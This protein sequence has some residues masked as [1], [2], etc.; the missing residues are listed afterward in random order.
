[1]HS[2]LLSGIVLSLALRSLDKEERLVGWG[3]FISLGGCLEL[4]DLVLL[5]G[6]RVPGLMGM[7]TSTG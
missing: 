5:L 3:Y 2:A 4:V 1:M 7:H 6:D